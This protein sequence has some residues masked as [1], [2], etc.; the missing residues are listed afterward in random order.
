MLFP[1][2]R[3][4]FSMYFYE[5]HFYLQKTD[6]VRKLE[7]KVLPR[8]LEELK[9]EGNDFRWDFQNVKS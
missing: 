7:F 3:L 5:N 2:E 1:K 6:T 8:L 4:I 9:T